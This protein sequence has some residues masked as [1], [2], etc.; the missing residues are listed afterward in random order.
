MVS[1]E[2]QKIG[3]RAELAKLTKLLQL[4]SIV[5]GRKDQGTRIKISAFLRK[6][7][8]LKPEE[9]LDN[10]YCEH[11]HTGFPSYPPM[12][13]MTNFNGSLLINGCSIKPG[14]TNYLKCPYNLV[15]L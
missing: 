15:N 9:I 13:Y 10:I 1:D 12:A 6:G 14:T 4:R 2:I 7:C 3:Q 11:C 5:T 8:S